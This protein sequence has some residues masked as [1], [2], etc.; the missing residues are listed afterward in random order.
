MHETDDFDIK[1]EASFDQV[2]LAV[3]TLR[4]T[5]TKFACAAWNVQG[6]RA[7]DRFTLSYISCAVLTG[8]CHF[9]IM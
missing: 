1:V 8:G 6:H 5:K 2:L 9:P 7:Y 3:L 4:K